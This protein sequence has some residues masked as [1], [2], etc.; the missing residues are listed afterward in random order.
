MDDT[1]YDQDSERSHQTL[2]QGF[3]ELLQQVFWENRPGDQNLGSIE[4]LIN[5]SERMP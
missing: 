4:D 3:I 2:R 5:R 1:P